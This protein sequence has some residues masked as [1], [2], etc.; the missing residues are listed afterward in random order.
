[1]STRFEQHE[2]ASCGLTARVQAGQPTFAWDDL[3]AEYPS[4]DRVKGKASANETPATGDARIHRD[5]L[6]GRTAFY[7]REA[8][9][10]QIKALQDENREL[11]NEEVDLRL[12]LAK[13]QATLSGMRTKKRALSEG[14]VLDEAASIIPVRSPAAGRS[15][16]HPWGR[17]H[18]DSNADGASARH[19]ARDQRHQEEANVSN[20]ARLNG[21]I[22]TWRCC[23]SVSVVSCRHAKWLR[24]IPLRPHSCF[25]FSR[26]TTSSA[27]ERH[28]RCALGGTVQ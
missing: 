23:C 9:T 24:E 26:I 16:H 5:P 15:V 21:R 12:R 14:K 20:D 3:K 4:P 1:M 11:S 13:A 19:D 18:R 7:D 17:K 2:P 28:P 8:L 22:R 27:T 25:C 6:N 10:E